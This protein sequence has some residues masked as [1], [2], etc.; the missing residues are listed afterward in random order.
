MEK[1]VIFSRFFGDFL[2]VIFHGSY[3]TSYGF[4]RGNFLGKIYSVFGVKK[5]PGIKIKKRCRVYC[6]KIFVKKR[7]VAVAYVFACFFSG[8]F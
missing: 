4:F 5:I 8:V 1:T 7:L 6:K 2:G 3:G